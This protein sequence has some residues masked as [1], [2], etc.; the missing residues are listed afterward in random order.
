MSGAEAP[1]DVEYWGT[2][3]VYWQFKEVKSDD[4]GDD[5]EKKV[6]KVPLLRVYTV[7]N[8][9]QVDDPDG[10]LAKYHIKEVDD[11]SKPVDPVF[12]VAKEVMDATKADITYGGNRAFYS[13]PQPKDSWPNHKKGDCIQ[14]PHPSQFVTPQDFYYTMFHE[15]GHWTEVR[16]GWNEEK[17]AM[18]ELVAEMASCFLAQACN[19]PHSDVM[20]N[21]ERYL[22]SWLGRMGDDPSFIFKA[23]SQASKVCEHVLAYSGRDEQNGGSDEDHKQPPKP[24]KARKPRAKAKPKGGS[25]KKAKAA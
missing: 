18:N 11:K 22:A 16:V 3:I 10:K 13:T 6:R 7:F 1:A 24:R 23:S 15:L 14:C 19:I 17:Y 4:T 21:H 2:K 8:L 12:D 5:G 9:E 25:R 20:D